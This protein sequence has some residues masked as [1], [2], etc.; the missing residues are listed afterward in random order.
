MIPKVILKRELQKNHNTKNNII[1][2]KIVK[3]VKDI[4]S[5]IKEHQLGED[6]LEIKEDYTP[7]EITKIIKE[8]E[9]GDNFKMLEAILWQCEIWSF[10]YKGSTD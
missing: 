5:R 8:L 7:K 2:K 4:T 1:P 9:K 6:I 10:E 3:E